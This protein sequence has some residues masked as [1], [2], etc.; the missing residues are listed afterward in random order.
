LKSC[1]L[2]I[3]FPSRFRFRS[4]VVCGKPIPFQDPS[5]GC[6]HEFFL[7][8]APFFLDFFEYYL[9]FHLI[10]EGVSGDRRVFFR[11]GVAFHVSDGGTFHPLPFRSRPKIPPPPFLL[12][13]VSEATCPPLARFPFHLHH[14]SFP[15][16]FQESIRYS[17]LPSYLTGF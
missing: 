7:C 16:F 17:S 1:L 5:T 10:N 15:L 8:R 9:S 13:P 3:T 11:A 14:F 4:L 12:A 2:G 6:S